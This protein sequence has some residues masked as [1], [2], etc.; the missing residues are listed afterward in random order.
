MNHAELV[1][2]AEL[3]PGLTVFDVAERARRRLA[4]MRGQHVAPPQPRLNR[5][6]SK[7]P[8]YLDADAGQWQGPIDWSSLDPASYCGPVHKI[9]HDVCSALGIRMEQL[10]AKRRNRKI[11]RPRQVA[12]WLCCDRTAKSLPEIGRR[13]GGLDHTTVLHSRRIV[14]AVI[15]A[16]G[17]D[18]EGLPNG[19][20]ALA[21][22]A[23]D[24]DKA[25]HVWRRDYHRKRAAK[26]RSD[27]G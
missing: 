5:D 22:L 25:E 17:L 23:A 18:V 2:A 10:K 7:G 19:A 24:W 21:I 11:V 16:N 6:R 26:A 1:R 13:F 8:H 15:Q 4:V 20:A 27:H 12:L 14:E 9:C 3:P